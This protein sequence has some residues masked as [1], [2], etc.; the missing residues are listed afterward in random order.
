MKMSR[1]ACFR[2]VVK[3]KM[4]KKGRG[5]PEGC[6]GKKIWE[7]KSQRTIAHRTFFPNHPRTGNWPG[8]E[9][10]NPPQTNI[11]YQA[12]ILA[13]SHLCFTKKAWQGGKRSRKKTHP[14]NGKGRE[15]AC[16]KKG[17]G[18]QA[19]KTQSIDH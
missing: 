1:K 7:R 8:T 4:E 19:K 18:F 11:F 16:E 17:T 5:C 6:R 3:G 9:G 12:T 13:K 2:G 14:G 10:R 15:G